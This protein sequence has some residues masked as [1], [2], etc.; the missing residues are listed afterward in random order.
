MVHAPKELQ[1][2]LFE[3]R[4]QNVLTPSSLKYSKIPKVLKLMT[5]Q[6][7][8]PSYSFLSTSKTTSPINKEHLFK[9][10]HSLFTIRSSVFGVTTMKNFESS[11]TKF[12]TYYLSV[13]YLNISLKIA[14]NLN[15]Y[16]D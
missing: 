11:S 7:I 4:I 10:T 9:I 6:N 3:A 16:Y 5:L 14:Q 13:F 15:C 2:P 1:P 12:W 8:M